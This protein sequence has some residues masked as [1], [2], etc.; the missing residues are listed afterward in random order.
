MIRSDNRSR[1]EDL[2]E[3]FAVL[4]ELCRQKS[5]EIPDLLPFALEDLLRSVSQLDVRARATRA[6]T[7]TSPSARNRLPKREQRLRSVLDRAPMMVRI[8]D[9]NMRP[10]W[11]NASWRNLRGPKR[12]RTAEAWMAEIH[13]DDRVRCAREWGQAADL[14]RPFR[15][16]YRVLRANGSS[17]WVLELGTPQLGSTGV[18][19]GY[20]ATAIEITERRSTEKRLHL[21][22]ESA[23]ILSEAAT[24]EDAAPAMLRALCDG[25]DARITCLWPAGASTPFV[26]DV[27][28]GGAPL[29]TDA[30]LRREVEQRALHNLLN[31]SLVVR[32]KVR[33]VLAAY[34]D[35]PHAVDEALGRALSAQFAQFLARTDAEAS[36]RAL[37]SAPTASI[38]AYEARLH[39]LASDL[40]VAEERARKQ[41]ACDLHDGLSQTIALARMKLC[42]LRR[43]SA[44]HVDG[45]LLTSLGELEQLI[46]C[47]NRSARSLTF[48]LCPPALHESGL[49]S[50]L[51][52]LVESIQ[53]R[54]GIAI[55]LEV[56]RAPAIVDDQIR[57]IFFRAI[58]ELLINAA[59]H[60]GA[61][62]VR[63]RLASD[64]ELVC[65]AVEDDG[66]G[67]KRESS[68]GCGSGLFS[69]RERLDHVGGSMC[70]DSAPGR[71]TKIQLRAPSAR[72]AKAG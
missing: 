5:D 48:E 60:A 1:L 44:E 56:E 46:D 66:V 65:A 10:R 42:V 19:N 53:A 40:L 33:G 61:R 13:P 18:L 16:E 6:D 12:E 50:A 30:D 3:Q 9:A 24:L 47:A 37:A 27:A 41:L 51:S 35:E 38:A 36:V 55:A 72:T 17:V 67:M 29:R 4:R 64:G 39:A 52:G 22:Y 57:V 45:S 68:T 15:V 43:R 25:L 70:V 62:S 71:G 11:S 63:V 58:R 2:R 23:R 32:G 31:V 69:I 34:G 28:P 21:Q 8:V 20:L 26:H 7:A 54:Y 49:A 59:K 14:Q